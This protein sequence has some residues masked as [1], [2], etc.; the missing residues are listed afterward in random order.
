MCWGCT[1]IITAITWP[2]ALITVA[3][4][5]DNPWG[6]CIR[7]SAQVG[8]H[9]ADVLL[10]RQ[11]VGPLSPRQLLRMTGALCRV[12]GPSH[13]LATVL[14]PGSSSTVFLSCPGGKGLIKIAPLR[15]QNRYR[16]LCPGCEGIIEDAILLG[17]PVTADLHKWG[18][19]T[20]VVSGRIVNG[21]C[22]GDWLLKF[23]YR[24]SSANFRIAGLQPILCENR[25]MCNVDLSDVVSLLSIYLLWNSDTILR[26]G[27][28]S[29]VS[30][31]NVCSVFNFKREREKEV[32]AVD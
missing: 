32:M 18:Q 5:I 24:T 11:H 1:G 27:K 17:A 25:R 26:M 10:S 4:V 15:D 30:Y 14:G 6:V 22:R 13:S 23:L 19:L 7:R 29:N 16:C 12:R 3:G 9:L 20:R 21:Y 2:S 31:F 8:R 28:T